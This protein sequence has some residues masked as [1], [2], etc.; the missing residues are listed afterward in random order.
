[1]GGTLVGGRRASAHGRG[2]VP[3]TGADRGHRVLQVFGIAAFVGLEVLI[4][5]EAYLGLAAFGFG[6]LWLLPALAVAAYLAADLLSG[7]VHFL[8]D[9]FG[10]ADTPI[11]GRG[12]IKPFRDHHTAPHGIVENGFVGT[13][14]NN[15]LAAVPV[16]LLVWLL[17]PISTA[18]WGLLFGLSFLLLCVAAFLTNQF[19]KWAHMDRA[20]GWV[21]W[22]QRRGVVLSRG[23]HDYHHT[24][25]YDTYYC[26]TVG[27]WNPLLDRTRFFE[28]AERFLRRVVPGTDPRLR[29]ER[30]GSL[31]G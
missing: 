6:Y 3:A 21:A 10:S 11:L 7:V 12:F 4:G 14:G 30:E 2:P 16:M 25:P 29:S 13:N 17:V 24:A 22:L 19:H 26:I 27:F 20:P 23:H 9:N 18:V 28:R 1:M 31:N 5:W 8:A 15:S